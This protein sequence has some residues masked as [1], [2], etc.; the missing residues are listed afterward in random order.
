MSV[1]GIE[2][3]ST[4]RLCCERLQLGH[5]NAIARIML[6]PRIG[7]WLWPSPTPPTMAELRRSL[8]GDIRHWERHGF[9]IW[10]LRDRLTGEPVGRGG[11][12]WTEP[13][14]EP[15]IEVSWAV[16]P[17]RW[18]EGLATEMAEAATGAAFGPLDIEELIA[19]TQPHN[20]ASRRVMEK[21]GFAYDF[22]FVYKELAHVMYRRRRTS[23]TAVAAD[24]LTASV[25]LTRS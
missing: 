18:G 22:D 2:R 3:V 1:V 14:G 21:T 9:G 10:L 20:V 8:E 17:E 23:S 13:N 12:R 7:E 15:E 5:A 25:P 19:F 4:S 16:V 11:L 6:D 24:T